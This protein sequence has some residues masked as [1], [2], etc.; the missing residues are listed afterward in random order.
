MFA[1]CKN[2]HCINPWDCICNNGFTGMLCDET[3]RFIQSINEKKISCY[4]LHLTGF[5]ICQ[6]NSFLLPLK[7]ISLGSL[8]RMRKI[9]K[10]FHYNFTFD[11]SKGQNGTN[12]TFLPQ[13]SYYDPI[14]NRLPGSFEEIQGLGEILFQFDCEFIV[15]TVKILFCRCVC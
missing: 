13:S 2:G 1:G 7:F 9:L 8:K 4:N 11:T 5:R 6:I 10:S 12:A 3:G 15:I 14:A